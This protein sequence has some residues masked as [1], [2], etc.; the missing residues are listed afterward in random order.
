MS[1]IMLDS[2]NAAAVLEAIKAKLKWRN[3]EIRA[4]AGYVD[5]N[6]DFRWPKEAWDQ[7]HAA[8]CAQVTITVTGTVSARVA[9][10]ETGDLTPLSASRWAAGEVHAGR[11]PVLYV[12]RGNKGAVIRACA[13]AGLG[14]DPGGRYGLWVATLDGEFQDTDHT[15]LRTQP[16]VVA[17]QY[18][19]TKEHDLDVDV[20]VLTAL[21][22]WWLFPVTWQQHAYQLALQLGGVVDQLTSMLKAHAQ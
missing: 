3:M 4:A 15:D 20:S 18:L 22:D 12:N 9:D 14:P 13:A 16:G 21:G 17:V 19:G 8:G 1:G 6:P 2:T 5:G 7:V 11:W 10:V